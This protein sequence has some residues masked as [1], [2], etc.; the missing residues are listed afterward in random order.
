MPNS[1]K[2]VGGL[3]GYTQNIVKEAGD[4]VRAY[5]RAD[6]A[7]GLIGP[8]TDAQANKLRKQQDRAGGQL[9]GSLVGNKYDSKGRRTN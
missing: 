1:G 5:K 6:N 9:L 3:K 2:Q 8:G 7:R 4:F